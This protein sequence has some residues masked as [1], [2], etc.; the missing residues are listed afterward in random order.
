MS[1]Q[2]SAMPDGAAQIGALVQFVANRVAR[3]AFAVAA[4]IAGLH[5]EVGH[6]AMERQAVEESLA[7]ERDEVLDRQRRVEHGE[8]E[9]NE[10]AIGFDERLRRDRR[11]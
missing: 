3:S 7:G 6:D 11:I 1:A 10:A 2:S 9:L 4:R 8:L 5:D